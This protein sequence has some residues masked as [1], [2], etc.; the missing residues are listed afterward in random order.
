MSKIKRANDAANIYTAH[1]MNHNPP[2]NRT[3]LMRNMYT[4]IITELAVNR[5]KWTGLPESVDVRF[6]E[7]T[8]FYR[9]LSVFYYDNDYEKHFALQ[10]ANN[11]FIN[12][13]NNPTSY[14]VVGNNF[15]GKTLGAYN[16]DKKYLNNE[17]TKKAIPI[18]ANYLRQPDTDI[19]YIYADKLAETDRTIEIN[20]KNARRNK[21][22]ATSDNLR[23]SATNF[24]RQLDEGH[25]G[26]QISNLGMN[27]IASNIVAFDMGINVDH[28]EKLHIIRTR[29]WNECMGLLGIENA[30]QDKKERL[31]ASEVD[32]NND[33]TSAMRYVN[34]NARRFACDMINKVHG[35]NVKVEYNTDVDRQAQQ[36]A[37]K[38]E[39]EKE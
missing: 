11:G 13:M 5:F 36:M 21:V 26:I 1:M 12:M 25:D 33:Q 14:T 16:P 27:E 18:W 20:A 28:L 6:L 35:L 7:L 15:V 38:N 34:L 23:L 22:I 8:L 2:Q 29:F 9:A 31:V 19:V 37:P 39:G 32:A 4:R 30:N 3:I 24:N 10:G 17:A